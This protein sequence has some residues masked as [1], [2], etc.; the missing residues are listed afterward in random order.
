MLAVTPDGHVSLR[1]LRD[2]PYDPGESLAQA[3][4]S[5]P[6]LIFPG[7]APAAIEDDGQRARRTAVAMDRSGRLLFVVSPT[8]GFTL[9]GFADWLSHSDLDVER[10]LNLDG[11]SST[12]LYLEAGAVSEQIDS[13]GPLPMVLFVEPK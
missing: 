10:A 1:A 11:G 3:L 8:S 5:F 4:Q 9:R 12:G 7:G 2:Q 6:M 13:L